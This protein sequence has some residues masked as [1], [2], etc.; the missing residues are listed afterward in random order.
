MGVAGWL[1]AIS[2]PEH[3]QYTDC[4]CSLPLSARVSIATRVAL[5]KLSATSIDLDQ[6]RLR[7]RLLYVTGTRYGFGRRAAC[8]YLRRLTRDY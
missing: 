8:S 4:S 6:K 5:R 2:G 1:S 3:L 7:A